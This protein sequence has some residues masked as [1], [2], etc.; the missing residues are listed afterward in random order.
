MRRSTG[1]PAHPRRARWRRRRGRRARTCVGQRHLGILAG[2]GL[3]QLAQQWLLGASLVAVERQVG[4]DVRAR[5][6]EHVD[7]RGERDEPRPLAGQCGVLEALRPHAHDHAPGVRDPRLVTELGERDRPERRGERAIGDLADEEVHR[8]RPDEAGHEQVQ[9]P[10][11][12]LVRGP[13]LLEHAVAHDREAVTQRH[14]LG[15][16]V[17]DI[18]RRGVQ[19]ALEADDLGAHLDAQLGV[20]VGQG[21]VHEEGPGVAHDGATHGH[22]L[23]LT[24]REMA[25][26]ALELVG[27]AQQIGGMSH[28]AADLR[29]RDL[30]AA[31]RE[32]HVARHRHV[33][34][35]RVVLEHHRDIPVLG[36]EVVD[37]AVADA[38]AAGGDLLQ[39][40]D[41]PQQRGL[42]A[43]GRADE[44]RELAVRDIEAEVVHG[45][46][47]VAVALA[48]VADLDLGHGSPIASG[49]RRSGG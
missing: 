22:A 8:R 37:H 39:P 43:T 35:E 26:L 25:G 20:E 18:H 31:Q 13:D 7:G 41:H 15:L 28:L 17:R 46:C 32:A 5:G 11:I 49:S 42:P 30:G 27:D 47:P 45:D 21:L 38:D 19:P 3:R 1:A 36:R 23:A 6:L 14:R 12:E 44:D 10:L 9:R 34:V 2:R 48:H 4:V 40:G 16:I 29:G 24:A 33:R